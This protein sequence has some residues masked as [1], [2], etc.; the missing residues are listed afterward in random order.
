MAEE[1][2]EVRL[3]QQQMKHKLDMERKKKAADDQAKREMSDTSSC[4]RH[5]RNAKRVR[6]SRP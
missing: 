4:R 5:V 6:D 1:I 3:L 2:H